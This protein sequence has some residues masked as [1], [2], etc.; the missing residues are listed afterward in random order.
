LTVLWDTSILIDV[1]RGA[2]AA[3]AYAQ[4]LHEVPACSEISRVEV[5]RG[6]RSAERPATER[7]LGSI[8]W[9]P[10]DESIARRAGALGREWGRSH[11]GIGTADL[12]VA[13]SAQ[14]LGANL[15]TSNIRHYPMFD[16]L[17]PPYGLS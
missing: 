11:P 4:A 15:A 14:E 12:V 17:A 13:A 7:L 9:I 10:L 16:G 6:V 5:L 2:P 8:I 1:L 3:V